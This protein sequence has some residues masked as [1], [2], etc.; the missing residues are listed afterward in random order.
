MLSVSCLSFLVLATSAV[1]TVTA[2]IVRRSAAP[3]G[4]TTLAIVV[5]ATDLVLGAYQGRFHFEP[6]SFSV[7]SAVTPPGDGTRVFNTDSASA[8]VIRFAGYTVNTG[9]FRSQDVLVLVVRTARSLET[10]KLAVDL[11]VATDLQGKAVPANRI[12]PARGLSGEPASH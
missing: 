1:P 10:A 3:S 5:R 9:G 7:V 6:G 11:D 12:V 8:G 2:S 4:E